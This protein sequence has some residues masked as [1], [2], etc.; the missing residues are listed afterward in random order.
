MQTL[1]HQAMTEERDPAGRA[2]LTR[3]LIRP[4]LCAVL[5]AAVSRQVI[6]SR[7][8][9]LRYLQVTARLSRP[10]C[11]ALPGELPLPPGQVGMSRPGV[12]RWGRRQVQSSWPGLLKQPRWAD[13]VAII[14][15]HISPEASTLPASSHRKRI[16]V[17]R[18]QDQKHSLLA[19]AQRGNRVE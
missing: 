17:K 19:S 8:S 9:S 15:S 18:G 7:V 10:A 5:E 14:N 4:F 16:P 13:S 12:K 2:R 3:W 1:I 11:L 6:T